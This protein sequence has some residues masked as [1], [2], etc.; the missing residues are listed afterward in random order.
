VVHC[1]LLFGIDCYFVVFIFYFCKCR[2]F[3]QVGCGERLTAVQMPI[4]R[5]TRRGIFFGFRSSRCGKSSALIVDL[6]LVSCSL[7]D[8][9]V[10]YSAKRGLQCGLGTPQLFGLGKGSLKRFRLRGPGLGIQLR[11]LALDS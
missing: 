6:A 9:Y 2:P 4:T 7:D 5:E 8:Q 11:G 10:Q 3:T 1:S